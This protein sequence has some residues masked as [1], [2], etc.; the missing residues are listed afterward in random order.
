MAVSAADETGRTVFAAPDESPD[1]SHV[2]H[3]SWRWTPVVLVAA[4]GSLSLLR[5]DVGVGSIAI[6]VAFWGI[7]I[8]LPGSLLVRA[9]LPPR[10]YLFD[11]LTLGAITGVTAQILSY[12]VLHLIGLG[13]L[14]RWWFLPVLIAFA[15]IPTL[16]THWW[17]RH[18]RRV[19]IGWSWAVAGLGLLVIVASDGGWFSPNPLPPAGG[20]VD[21]DAWWHLAVVHELLRE[22]PAQIPQVAGEPF[23]YHF[24]AHAHIAVATQ[25]TG[26]DPELLLLR[27]WL[28]PLALL[29][30]AMLVLLAVEVVGLRWAGPIAVWLA[31]GALAGGYLWGDFI[32]LSSTPIRSGS[33]SQILALPIIS[34]AAWAIV[35]NCS[36]PMSDDWPGWVGPHRDRCRRRQ[37]DHRSDLDRRHPHGGRSLGR[38]EPPTCRA[39]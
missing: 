37:T 2:S 32:V 11:T 3:R 20:T 28:I 34:A 7:G 31:V 12:L 9:L 38:D 27:L 33:P 35:R 17:V 5:N 1:R 10:Y 4:V 25:S 6:F 39:A 29:S 21:R 18:A 13:A 26:L 19:S 30:V 24:N 15:T 23:N 14:A 36:D 22:G 16:R 8:L